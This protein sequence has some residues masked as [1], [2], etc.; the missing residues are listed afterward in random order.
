[1]SSLALTSLL[2]AYRR[3]LSVRRGLSD[4]TVSGYLS[5]ARSLLNYLA[6]LVGMELTEATTAS[7]LGLGGLELDDLRSWLGS[8]Q[9]AGSSR[10]SLARRSAAIK[11]FTAWLTERGVTERD[12]GAR[13]ASPTPDSRLPHVLSADDASRL[14]NYS[15]DVA[16]D[17]NKS[18]IRNWA[19]CELLYSSAL[20]VSEL[21]GL[22]QADVEGDTVRVFGKGST[23]RIVPLGVPAQE[24][25]AAYLDVR[26]LFLVS[27]TDALF[28]G[29]RGGRL[30]PRTLRGIL[31]RLSA[32]AG[33]SDTAP[34]DLRHSA[35]THMLEGGSDLRAVQEFLGHSSLGTTQRYTHVSPDRLRQAF[36]QAHPRA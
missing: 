25:L 24:A 27:P 31:H 14:L 9:R 2:D 20:R 3:E 6:A 36:G 28:L 23:E 34:H 32:A 5:D 19:A 16:E 15:R 18:K 35:A 21:T 26:H 13:L 30:D 29:D 10:S 22:N 7:D 33:V 11:S 4:H 8:Q 17:G 12:A 1:M